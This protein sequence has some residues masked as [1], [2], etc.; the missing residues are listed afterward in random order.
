VWKV[1]T[2][3]EQLR[4][5]FSYFPCL[6]SLQA[7]F[8]VNIALE[9]TTA[10]PAPPAELDHHPMSVDV[11]EPSADVHGKLRVL[12]DV[13]TEHAPVDVVDDL[14]VQ[15]PSRS[16]NADDE[17]DESEPGLDELVE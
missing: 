9:S 4:Y 8:Q 14:D 17:L 15:A 3:V 6:Q 11:P 5:V 10:A 1:R 16:S 7:T 2:T 13:R 12:P